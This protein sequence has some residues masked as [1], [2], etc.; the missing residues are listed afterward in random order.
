MTKTTVENFKLKRSCPVTAGQRS[1]LLLAIKEANKDGTLGDK[2]GLRY[3]DFQFQ[4]LVLR[5]LRM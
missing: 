3:F 5:L 4:V 1:T 2:V